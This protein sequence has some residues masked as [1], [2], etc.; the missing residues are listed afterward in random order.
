MIRRT[1]LEPRTDGGSILADVA[2]RDRLGLLTEDDIAVIA[3]VEVK[4]VRQWRSER[5]GPPF[6]KIG[7]RPLYR[8]DAL[9]RW[10]AAGEQ[11]T[12]P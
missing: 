6:T 9:Q 3:G 7:R 5:T 10:L 12:Q 8:V 4:T 1:D 11:E 2:L